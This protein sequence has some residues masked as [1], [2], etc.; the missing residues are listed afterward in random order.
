VMVNGVFVP[1]SLRREERLEAGDTVAI[2]PPVA[3]G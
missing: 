3:G 2:W 1:C